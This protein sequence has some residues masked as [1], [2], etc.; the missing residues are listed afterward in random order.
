MDGEPVAAAAALVFRSLGLSRVTRFNVALDA[1]SASWQKEKANFEPAAQACSV[2]KMSSLARQIDNTRIALALSF[3][4]GIVRSY[5][6]RKSTSS[7][8]GL[9]QLASWRTSVSRIS[10][11]ARA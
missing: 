2:I 7:Q 3:V 1:C 6:L 5:A 10:C 11:A 8:S 9:D 4:G